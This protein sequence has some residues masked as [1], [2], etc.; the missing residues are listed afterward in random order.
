[1]HWP[2]IKQVLQKVLTIDIYSCRNRSR[3]LLF[4]LLNSAR[5]TR[6]SWCSSPVAR[7]MRNSHSKAIVH[8]RI[9]S[10]AA[11]CLR[12][13]APVLRLADASP[14]RLL[15]GTS[16]PSQ[17]R[18]QILICAAQPRHIRSRFFQVPRGACASCA[19]RRARNG[20]QENGDWPGSGFPAECWKNVLGEG[21]CPQV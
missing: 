8:C 13:T 16:F 3:I 7:T 19:P 1:M 2:E 6:K 5:L 18:A 15:R 20:K 9:S 14:G 17:V 21:G 10:R 11:L 12:N 4:W